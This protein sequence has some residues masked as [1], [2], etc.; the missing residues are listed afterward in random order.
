MGFN[1]SNLPEGATVF[2]WN[3]EDG[4]T[5][6]FAIDPM[7]VWAADHMSEINI[8]IT[9]T[10][11]EVAQEFRAKGSIEEYKLAR[12]T[13][14]SFRTPIFYIETSD[15]TH[16]LVDGHNRYVYAAE[17]GI[18]YIPTVILMPDQWEPFL[19]EPDPDAEVI[20]VLRP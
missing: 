2:E 1:V 4:K 7:I 18:D 6:F 16:I 11:K 20:M 14:E 9:Q 15:K 3:G 8:C 10:F 19:I 5:M 17:H 13:P 12:I